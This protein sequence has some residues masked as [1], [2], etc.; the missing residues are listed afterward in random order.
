LEEEQEKVDFDFANN[1]N[2]KQG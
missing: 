1:P 2:E